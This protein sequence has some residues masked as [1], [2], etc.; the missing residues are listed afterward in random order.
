MQLVTEEEL[1]QLLQKDY[2]IFEHFRKIYL[3]FT[4]NL[5]SIRNCVTPLIWKVP[6]ALVAPRRAGRGAGRSNVQWKVVWERA[7]ALKA[8]GSGPRC[9]VQCRWGWAG[10]G[11][12]GGGMKGCLGEKFNMFGSWLFWRGPLHSA[13]PQHTCLRKLC[14][15]HSII[16]TQSRHS[17]R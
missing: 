1:C 14:C 2:V 7:P 12:W 3:L 15:Q 4:F 13:W 9:V 11:M 5:F 10:P 17:P 16:I 6:P 8:A